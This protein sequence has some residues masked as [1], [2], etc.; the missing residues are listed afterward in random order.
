M[1]DRKLSKIPKANTVVHVMWFWWNE[2]VSS[3]LSG[4]RLFIYFENP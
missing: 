2:F 1:A 4:E 3:S